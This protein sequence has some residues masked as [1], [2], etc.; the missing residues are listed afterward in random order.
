MLY[1]TR[2]CGEGDYFKLAREIDPGI[3]IQVAYVEW[4]GGWEAAHARDTHGRMQALREL[5]DEER[6]ASAAEQLQEFD[7]SAVTWVCTSGSF[8]CGLTGA[9]LQARHLEER[10][11]VPVSST[12]LAFLEAAVAL[13]LSRVSVC[14]VYSEVVTDEFIRFLLDGGVQTINRIDLSA[15]SDRDLATWD[16]ARILDIAEMSNV[17]SAQ[18]ILIPETALHTA[19]ILEELE[20]QTGKPVLTATQVTLWH[21]LVQLGADRRVAGLGSLFDTPAGFWRHGPG[22]SEAGKSTSSP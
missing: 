9:R 15:D 21:T 11:D 5:G 1:P 19:E 2:D 18:A 3:E 14:S 12:S 6:L 8:L 10:L 17:S 7:P 22:G 20:M 13:R 4:P 16:H